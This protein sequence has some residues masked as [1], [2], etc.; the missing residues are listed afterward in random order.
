MRSLRPT[1][2]LWLGGSGTDGV[3]APDADPVIAD[4]SGAPA[5]AGSGSQ[6]AQSG[7]PRSAE[8]VQADAKGVVAATTPAPQPTAAVIG[9]VA[10]AASSASAVRITTASARPVVASTEPVASS[11]PVKDDRVTPARKNAGW[12]LAVVASAALAVAA[13]YWAFRP[14]DDEVAAS[15]SAEN[16]SP[17]GAKA[18]TPATS[19]SAPAKTV[20][21]PPA[22]PPPGSTE[23]AADTKAE[24]PPPSDTPSAS[25]K[26][27][28]SAD[29]KPAA[30][31]E[32]VSVKVKV[33]PPTA[34]VFQGSKRLG[35]GDQTV[36]VTV[37]TPTKLIILHRGYDY[38]RVKIDGTASEVTVKLRKY[39]VAADAADKPKPAP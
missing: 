38:R 21:S 20:D 7:E 17:K 11:I 16:V 28:E 37:G 26:A 19:P 24:A 31:G 3:D 39:A 6:P 25:D 10:A 2:K 29:Q 18:A 12:N 36:E 1:M 9:T 4:D 22:S 5:S 35:E 13:G 14:H 30:T 34:I 8:S 15:A 33:D 27:A 23:V 32:T